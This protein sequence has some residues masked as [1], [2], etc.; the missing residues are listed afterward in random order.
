MD[1]SFWKGRK[2]TLTGH[3]G[4]K[5]SWMS[6]VLLRAG[7]KVTG[8][9]L[10][11]PTHPSLFEILNLKDDM[12]CHIADIRDL[13][14]ISKLIRDSQPEVLFHMAAQPLVRASYREPVETYGTNVMG[15]LHVMEAARACPHLKALVN[16][17]TD[18]CYENRE[19]VWPYRET[20]HLGG[21]D[22][23][24]SSKACAEILTSCYQRSFFENDDKSPLH[25]ASVRAGNVIGGGDWAEDRLVADI[26]R[27]FLNS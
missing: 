27:S 1:P 4:F 17:T 3:T 23:Y 20:D 12:Q 6:L 5:G 19:W 10:P 7:A 25:L 26:M 13:E 11:P 16:I 21:Y 8:V 22:P 14:K 9:A 24:S 2:V 15:T 18:K